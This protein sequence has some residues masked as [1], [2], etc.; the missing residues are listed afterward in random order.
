MKKYRI[1]VSEEAGFDL[2][3]LSEVIINEYKSPLTAF[4]Y[5]RDL[6]IEIKRL[7]ILAE[8]PPIQSIESLMRYGQAVRRLNYKKMAVI[9]YRT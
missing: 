9:I 8:S 1:E 7:S 3:R 6:K 4:R 5:V 2:D